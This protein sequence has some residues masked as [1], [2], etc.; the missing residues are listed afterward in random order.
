MKMLITG[1]TG[2][3]GHALA[4]WWLNEG[5]EVVIITRSH[6]APRRS[7]QG[8]QP[9]FLRWADLKKSTSCQNI[10]VA[11]NL[12]GETINQRWTESAK[13]RIV[14]SRIMP[15]RRLNEWV[16][17][18][19]NPLPLFISASGSSVYGSSLTGVF[20]E[21]SPPDGDDFLA[22]VVRQ[23]EASADS[24]PA[25]RT[26]K[27]RIAPV[28]STD[29]GA[30]PKM[31]LPFK[32]GIGGSIG[33]GKQPFSWIHI[34]DLV[35]LID[36]VVKDASLSGVVNASAPESV[37]NEEFGRAIAN[38]YSRP[39]WL[40]LPAW[41]LRLLLGEMSLLLLE[42]QRVYPSKA[43]EHGF[44]FQYGSVERALRALRQTALYN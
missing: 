44:T 14:A 32:L 36:F 39:F 30:Y 13:N 4:E 2:L 21:T 38:V 7:F 24:I 11:V 27:L 31:L 42:G 35:Q 26:V 17:S 10:D 40:P 1:G 18:I 28:L 20:D 15:A 9:S 5:H 12:A 41:S 33:S 8:K 37:T 43:L 29:D 25:K 19:G 23:W 6:S 22:D 16:Q 34:D 3:V